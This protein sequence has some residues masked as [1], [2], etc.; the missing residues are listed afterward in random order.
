MSSYLY[1]ML[2]LKKI[3]DFIFNLSEY[4][5]TCL[6]P[7]SYHEFL[8]NADDFEYKYFVL[9]END[10]IISFV[11]NVYNLTGEDIHM[12]SLFL[13]DNDYHCNMFLSNKRLSV[14]FSC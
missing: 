3:Y 1:C 13:K 7:L 11:F 12:I 9:K 2:D 14:E 8:D 5:D 6:K 10:K 4:K